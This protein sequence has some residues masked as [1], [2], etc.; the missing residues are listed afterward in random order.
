[1]F[2]KT[3]LVALFVVS[4][5]VAA[6]GSVFAHSGTQARVPTAPMAP[7][8]FCVPIPMPGC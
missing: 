7:K 1:M 6:T 3:V 8:G 2:K 4:A 5:A